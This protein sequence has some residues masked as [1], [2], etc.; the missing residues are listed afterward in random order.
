MCFSHLNVML[1]VDII[2]TGCGGYVPLPSLSAMIA[3]RFQM[4]SD[5]RSYSLSAHG[6]ATGVILIELAEQLLKTVVCRIPSSMLILT[7][8]SLSC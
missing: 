2:I 6:C 4:R 5:V 3:H 7:A 8:L 1:Q